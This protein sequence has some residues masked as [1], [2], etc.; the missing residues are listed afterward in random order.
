MEKKKNTK[1]NLLIVLAVI[2]IVVVFG[3]ASLF[4]SLINGLVSKEPEH[5][6]L[7]DESFA[8]INI[9]GTIQESSASPLDSYSYNHSNLINY[10][11][12]LMED[13][14]NHGILLRV[15]S[16]GGT[17][18]HSDE[19]Y[20]KLME[21]KE[22]TGRPIHAYFEQTAA[23][24]AYYISCAADYISANRNCWTG[25]IGVILS[26]TNA[27]GLYDKL[28]LEEIIIATGENKGMGSSAGELT[29]EQRAIYQGLVDESYEVF[30]DIVAQARNMDV[31]TVKTIAD[32]RVY[33]AKQAVENGLVDYVGSWE[34]AVEKMEETTGVQP[35]E[36]VFSVSASWIDY[37]L[38]GL[39]E[40]MPKS[41]VQVLNEMASSELCGVPLYMYRQ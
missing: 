31:E 26:Y 33:T 4:G 25:S 12:S 2:S 1:R 27:K 24:G 17:V 37:I 8:V 30:V 6:I 19:M 39:R 40:A 10:V 36:K 23:S 38:Y 32:G 11:D 9:A 22:V 34:E 41:D 20:L 29:D 14:S 28:G 13:P 5:S 35:Y 3:T 15:N 7:P 18:F 16:G 21:Y